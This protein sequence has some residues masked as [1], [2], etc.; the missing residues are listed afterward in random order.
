MSEERSPE[1]R[2]IVDNSGELQYSVICPC[3]WQSS[4]VTKVSMNSIYD[5]EFSEL[6]DVAIHQHWEKIGEA[7]AMVEGVKMTTTAYQTKGGPSVSAWSP[8]LVPRP[9]VFEDAQSGE[10]NASLWRPDK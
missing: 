10:A 7:S 6:T 1:I 8:G 3:G 5:I 2:F 9:L 4:W